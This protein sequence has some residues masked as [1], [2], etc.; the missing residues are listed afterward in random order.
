MVPSTRR[1]VRLRPV[2]A[3]GQSSEVDAAYDEF[4]RLREKGEKI[5]P[6]AFCARYPGIQKSLA[7]LLEVHCH[8]EENSDLLDDE[9]PAVDWPLPAETFAGFRLQRELG[10]GAFARVYL[11]TDPKLGDRPVAVKVSAHGAFEAATL[12]RI[13]HPNIVPVHSFREERGLTVVCMPYLG[14]ATLVQVLDRVF[15]QE[16]KV[17]RAAVVLEA[18][19]DPLPQNVPPPPALFR[20]GS[21][22]DAVRWIA[23]G[24]VEALTFL[25]GKGICHRDLKPSNVLLRPDGTPMLLDFNLSSD[26]QLPDLRLGGTLLY[27]APEQLRAMDPNGPR[28]PKLLDA[29]TDLFSLGVILYE[30]LTGKHPFAPLPRGLPI[31]EVLRRLLDRQRQ[32]FKPIRAFAPEVDVNLA[33]LVEGCLAFEP[34]C[35]P[36][37]AAALQRSLRGDQMLWRRT[38]RWLGKHPKTVGAVALLLL[39][40]AVGGYQLSQQEPAH[41]V[42]LNQ[43]IEAYQQGNYD[44]ALFFLNQSLEAN[45][46]QADAFF[47]R[48]LVYKKMGDLDKNQ[49]SLSSISFQNADNLKPDGKTKACMGYA[50]HRQGSVTPAIN[51]YGQAIAAGFATEE[52]HNNLGAIFVDQTKLDEAYL[53][54]NKALALNPKQPTI[55]HNLALLFFKRGLARTQLEKRAQ[56]EKGISH[57]QKALDLGKP[58]GE[59]AY[60]AAQLCAVAARQDP[61][62]RDPALNHLTQ[63][64]DLG[65][66][67]K[68]I[69]LNT[70]FDDL[71]PDPRFKLLAQRPQAQPSA[72]TLRVLDPVRD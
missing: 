18:I 25:H 4:C 10:Q 47:A 35:R 54:L 13:G 45:P 3:P 30:L 66:N 55:H 61:T 15:G 53:H 22:V 17:D 72:K 46:N 26:A 69:V 9:N 43:G 38:V 63:A 67:P 24:L 57:I 12:G 52:V 16:K 27:M 59:L 41:L 6:A 37:S 8:L 70:F 71:K 64:L 60:S 33:R 48:G 2:P 34:E 7:R 23:T 50:L 11:A 28:D 36:A 5:D 40:G 14:H 20:S 51:A 68:A 58:T 49:F 1:S 29:R 56:L 31:S 32:G 44:Q 65:V 42:Q 21:Y 62:W 19:A 39:A